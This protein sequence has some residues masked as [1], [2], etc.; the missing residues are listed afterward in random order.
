VLESL[1]LRLL[2]PAL[3]HQLAV[4]ILLRIRRALGCEQILGLLLEV[5][6]FLRSDDVTCAYL[7]LL[8]SALLRIVWH[9]LRLWTLLKLR[10]TR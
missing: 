8:H 3:V 6:P 1:E 5:R 7:A 9:S 4:L 10:L 2:H